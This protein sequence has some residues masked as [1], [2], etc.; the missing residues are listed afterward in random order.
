MGVGDAGVGVG[1]G[2]EGDGVGVG[3]G[4]VGV[5]V[6]ETLGLTLWRGDGLGLGEELCCAAAGSTSAGVCTLCGLGASSRTTAPAT[7]PT[8]ARTPPAAAVRT[9]VVRC[10]E[11]LHSVV[12]RSRSSGGSAAR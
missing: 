2:V 12:R 8:T 11:R 10:V 9:S 5:R 7:T 3:V 1:V 4:L 6:G